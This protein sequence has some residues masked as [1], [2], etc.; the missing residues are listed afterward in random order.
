MGL[1]P[2][3]KPAAIELRRNGK[4]ISVT[5]TP[6]NKGKVEGEEL[7]CPRWDMTVKTI[8]QFDNPGLYFHRKKGVY[9]YGVKY[10]GNAGQAG[11]RG[12]DILLKIDGKEA[13]T[14]DA[15]KA[16][17]KAAI[18]NVAT[19]HRIV[20]SVLR[21]GMLRQVVLDFARDYEKE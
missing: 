19:K 15:V 3:N 17:H 12:K 1:L 6:R 8:N 14:L 2:K 18:E 16:I 4:T 21:N 20:F 13:P 5:I 11:L 7:D 9:I 10:P